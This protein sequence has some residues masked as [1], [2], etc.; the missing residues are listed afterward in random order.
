MMRQ[1]KLEALVVGSRDT[2]AGTVY[3]AIVVLS[4]LTA[5]APAFEHGNW[6]LLAVLGVTVLVFWTAHVYTHVIGESLQEGHRLERRQ[7]IAIARRELAIPL[8][9]VLP[10]T[11]VGL[12]VVGAIGASTAL[13]LAAGISVAT[14]TIQGIRY[15]RLERLSRTGTIVSVAI[16]LSLG[17]ALVVLKVVVTH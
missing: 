9:A 16:N 7:V 4:V 12:G 2:I 13:W 14:L 8:A 10:M 1:V 6:H 17:L 3:G 5:G 11:M 15:A